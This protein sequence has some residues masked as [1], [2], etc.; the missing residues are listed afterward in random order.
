MDEIKKDSSDKRKFL[1][2]LF[3]EC[4]TYSRIYLNKEG[5]AYVGFC[6]KCARKIVIK[7]GEGGSDSRF[8]KSNVL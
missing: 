5:T 8:F 2:V 7:V 1:G 3:E 6:P 4:N